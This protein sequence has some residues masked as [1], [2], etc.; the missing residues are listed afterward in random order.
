MRLRRFHLHLPPRI[1][2]KT[3]QTVLSRP[4]HLCKHSNLNLNLTTMLPML[5][6]NLFAGW[7]FPLRR[8]L[9]TLL[10]CTYNSTWQ[11]CNIRLSI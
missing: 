11:H 4:P 1:L 6:R 2:F 10:S 9:K 3:I 5:N 7:A 8:K